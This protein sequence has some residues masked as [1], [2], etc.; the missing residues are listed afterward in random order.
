MAKWKN[1]PKRNEIERKRMFSYVCG[2]LNEMNTR[3]KSEWKREEEGKGAMG[4]IGEERERDVRGM[5]EHV[6]VL[7]FSRERTQTP[8]RHRT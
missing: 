8:Q 1:K 4:G 6:S 2:G 5:Q 3:E 7:S